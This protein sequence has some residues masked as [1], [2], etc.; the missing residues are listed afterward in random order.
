MIR[1]QKATENDLCRIYQM[2]VEA[3]RPLLDKYEDYATSPAAEPFER[4]LQRFAFDNV[5]YHLIMLDDEP[6]GA[7]RVRWQDTTYVLAQILITPKHQ[8][9][10]YG[11]ESIREIEK[12]YPDAT[13]WTLDTIA[14][15]EKLCCLYEKMGYRK[16]SHV[17]RVRE[18]MDIVD[19]E[20]TV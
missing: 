14:Q 19:F 6:I 4:T 2:Q 9:K 10:G 15:E 8:N 5:A 13:K 17:H 1:I 18:G 11:Q 16:T 3:F 20:K 12:L 7:I